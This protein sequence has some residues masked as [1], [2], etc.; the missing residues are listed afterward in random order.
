MFL[1][2]LPLL[3]SLIMA[4]QENYNN[5][6]LWGTYRPNLYFGTR[7]RLPNTLMTGLVWAG[8]THSQELGIPAYPRLN[9][10]PTIGWRHSCENSHNLS[11]YGW[12]KHDGRNFGSQ[13]IIDGQ[14]GWLIKTDFLKKPHGSK[15]KSLF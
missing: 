3:P 2:I 5:S 1:L 15:G 7:P 4:L 6:M 12:T 10:N 9:S 14:V 11:K 13:E 8:L